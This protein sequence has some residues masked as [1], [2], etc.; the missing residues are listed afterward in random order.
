M[1]VGDR[2][3][4]SV[5]ELRAKILRGKA[6]QQGFDLVFSDAGS[7]LEYKGDDFQIPRGSSVIVRRV[8]CGAV[9]AVLSPLEAVNETEGSYTSNPAKEPIDEFDDFG[10]DL[11]PFINANLPPSVQEIKN[12]VM[13]KNMEDFTGLRLDHQNLA[14]NN[15]SEAILGGS[16]QN[17]NAI[18]ISLEA[19][20]EEQR[21][22]NNNLPL[23]L[24]CTLCKYYLKDAVMIRCCHHSFCENCISRVLVEKGRCPKCFSGQCSVGDLLP[25]LSLRK[26]IRRF[27]EY[28]VLV[29]G[30]ENHDLQKHVPDGESGIRAEGIYC[31]HRVVKRELEVPQSP[32]ATG[33]GSNQVF[34]SCYE[35]QPQ[36]NVPFADSADSS[37]KREEEFWID[38][39]GGD[40]NFLAHGEH[41]EGIRTCL[42]CGSPDHL[43]RDCPTSNLTPMFQPGN[44]ALNGGM[45]TYGPPYMS[46]STIHP[47]RSYAN[48]YSNHGLM[49][50]NAYLAPAAPYAIPPYICSMCG[51]SFVPSENLRMGNM[52][53]PCH[54]EFF[55]LQRCKNRQKHSNENLPRQQFSGDKDF[56]PESYR[57]KSA[58]RAH[59]Y[60]S[61]IGKELSLGVTR[62]SF[63]RRSRKRNQRD[64]YHD[65][66][67]RYAD[68]KHKKRYDSSYGGRQKRLYHSRRLKSNPEYPTRSS[69]QPSKRR[70][71]HHYG[72]SKYHERMGCCEPSDRQKGFK[73]RV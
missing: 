43:I 30:L 7:G 66:V 32:A 42:T 38:R 68:D 10:A 46:N 8:P 37:A 12:N 6:S 35:Q 22:Q 50:F 39:E 63:T 23:E 2:A 65:S 51:G 36:R 24:K 48:M 25:N 73:G 21:K 13:N 62:E 9:P 14:T 34:E 29:S 56:F 60:K 71:K 61:P 45:R 47:F 17:G 3:S 44:Y 31:A 16:K 41:N 53:P 11:F 33:K 1:E 55:G 70:D 57:Y 67:D 27:L 49:P 72:E 5:R 26:A 69:D 18:N 52:G 19:R 20:V 58:E 28:Q 15:L 4:I 40:I 59:F 54:S 64:K